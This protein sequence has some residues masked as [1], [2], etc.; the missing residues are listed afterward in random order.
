MKGCKK[1]CI[2]FGQWKGRPFNSCLRFFSS[3]FINL[4]SLIYSSLFIPISLRHQNGQFKSMLWHHSASDWQKLFLFQREGGCLTP[5]EGVGYQKRRLHSPL[6]M[7]TIPCS[8]TSNGNGIVVG[9]GGGGGGLHPP[10]FFFFLKK[11]K[12]WHS[13]WQKKLF[14]KFKSTHSQFA[15]DIQK[16]SYFPSIVDLKLKPSE[17]WHFGA[18]QKITL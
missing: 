2:L 10:P 5:M 1:I 12:Y 16:D 6:K 14:C 18:K 15:S 17:G 3:L 4:F 9:T 7:T 8:I 11:T 13:K